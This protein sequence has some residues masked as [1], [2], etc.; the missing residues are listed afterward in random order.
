MKEDFGS[1]KKIGI[2]PREEKLKNK[3]KGVN[4]RVTVNEFQY[5]FGKSEISTKFEENQFENNPSERKI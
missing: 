2:Y 3:W 1:A 5:S 4:E